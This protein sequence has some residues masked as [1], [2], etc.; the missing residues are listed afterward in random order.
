MARSEI[1]SPAFVMRRRSPI[2]PNSSRQDCRF[3]AAT[4]LSATSRAK[5]ASHA[6]P[7][8]RASRNDPDEAASASAA[9]APVGGGLERIRTDR[10]CFQAVLRSD[11][12]KLQPFSA[13]GVANREQLV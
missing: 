8:C 5:L 6:R 3:R 11:R 10:G 13:L 1:A 9:L 2:S 12:W 7:A 4:S